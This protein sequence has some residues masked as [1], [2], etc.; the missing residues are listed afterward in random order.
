MR[1][2]LEVAALLLG[3]LLS[4]GHNASVPEC[5]RM[6]LEGDVQYVRVPL[7]VTLT[8]RLSPTYECIL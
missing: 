7:Q 2:V 6:S 1:R 5:S 8:H 4:A 3:T